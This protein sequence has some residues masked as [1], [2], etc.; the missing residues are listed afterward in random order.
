MTCY[1]IDDIEYDHEGVKWI[2]NAEVEISDPAGGVVGVVLSNFS[3]LYAG[4]FV[5]DGMPR[6]GA[7]AT[8]APMSLLEERAEE[9]ACAR[10][11]ERRSW[12]RSSTTRAEADDWDDYCMRLLLGS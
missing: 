12:A 10:H 11:N 3:A 8:G 7:L 4:G 9:L 6:D 1:S 5:I 2:F